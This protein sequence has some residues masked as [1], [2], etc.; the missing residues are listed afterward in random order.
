VLSGNAT[1]CSGTNTSLMVTITGGTGPYDFTIDNGIGAISNYNSGDPIPVSPGA[2]TTYN[3]VGNVIDASGCTVAGRGSATVTVNPSPVSA[4]LGGTS[5]ICVGGT[6]NLTVTITNGTGPFSFTIDN[7][8]GLINNY[9]SGDPIPVNP[10]A[11][12]TYS[13]TGNVTD[14]MGCT[15][16]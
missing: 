16:A 7:G 3:I 5:T 11:T 1:I 9:N 10:G 6:A 2:N 4:V 15:V 12:T 8:V 14:A 13:I